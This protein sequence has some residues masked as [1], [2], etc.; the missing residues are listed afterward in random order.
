MSIFDLIDNKYTM[1]GSAFADPN[2][3]HVGMEMDIYEDSDYLAVIQDPVDPET[4]QVVHK[5]SGKAV[6]RGSQKNMIKALH[7]ILQLRGFPWA[8]VHLDPTIRLGDYP[9]LVAI[10]KRYR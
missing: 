1:P 4:Y 5:P 7:Q 10:R 6:L 9:D 8:T 3:S 2:D